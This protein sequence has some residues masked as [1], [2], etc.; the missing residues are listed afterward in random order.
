LPKELPS[1][2]FRY[3]GRISEDP[4]LRE[5]EISIPEQE[6]GIVG[7]EAF[8]EGPHD[9]QA[10]ANIPE[11]IIKIDP[12]VMTPEL[13][14]HEIGHLETLPK[15]EVGSIYD[16]EETTIEG[17]YFELLAEYRA[18]MRSKIPRIRKRILQDIDT[19]KGI[20]GLTEIQWTEINREAM[21][22]SGYLDWLA[23]RE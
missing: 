16:Y 13:W 11:R 6:E 2:K 18:I 10:T 14:L 5:W 1:A 19:L 17:F 8:S 15:F 3:K 4:R 7:R 12:G 22:D 9:Y 21:Q 23:S 20:S